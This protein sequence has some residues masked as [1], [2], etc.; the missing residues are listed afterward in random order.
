MCS[1]L[2]WST[3][4]LLNFFKKIEKWKERGLYLYCRLRRKQKLKRISIR[5]RILRALW[6]HVLVV[7]LI[8]RESIKEKIEKR[9][10]RDVYL[11]CRLWRK[12]RDK[13][14]RQ[15]HKASWS[16]GQ[17]SNRI[18]FPFTSL[19]QQ[20]FWLAVPRLDFKGRSLE[21]ETSSRWRELGNERLF[22]NK[23]RWPS[24]I[25]I[26]KFFQLTETVFFLLVFEHGDYVLCSIYVSIWED[27]LATMIIGFVAKETTELRSEVDSA[28]EL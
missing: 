3:E 17:K 25:S 10:E 7:N 26:K 13:K 20:P 14:S 24:S 23:R 9:K 16:F 5:T 21:T 8:Y 15:I 19:V 4:N 12:Q 11:Y 6:V 2:I 1:S 27:K 22:L 18:M 28:A